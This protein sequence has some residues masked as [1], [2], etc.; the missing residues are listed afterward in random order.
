MINI[1]QLK[2]RTL[3]TDY[4]HV[5]AD[6]QFTLFK[7]VKG[8]PLSGQR[9]SYNKIN[10]GRRPQIGFLRGLEEGARETSPPL[11]NQISIVFC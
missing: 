5:C 4:I 2:Q 11:F 9:G 8:A 3:Y 7:H 10:T 6:E 1:L